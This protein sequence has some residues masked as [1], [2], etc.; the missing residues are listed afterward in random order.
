MALVGVLVEVALERVEL[1][2]ARR[3]QAAVGE[4]LPD[5]GPVVAL[6]GVPAPTQAAGDL[7][8]PAPLNPQAVDQFVLAAGGVGEL[9]GRVRRPGVR[10][11]CGFG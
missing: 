4:L 1:N 2:G 10:R 3:L 5:G 6:D 7:P 11:L 9:P 8:Q